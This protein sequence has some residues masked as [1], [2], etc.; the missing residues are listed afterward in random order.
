MA[1]DNNTALNYTDKTTI[2]NWFKTGLKPSQQ[3]FWSTWD[4]YWHKSEKLPI[5]SIS[6]LGNLLDGKAEEN[7]T[8]TNYATKEA[9]DNEIVERARVDALKLNKPTTNATSDYVLLADGSTAPKSDFGKVDKVMG[10]APDANKNVD[11]SGVA[12][13][14]TNA[15]QRFSGLADRSSDAT[16]N[17]IMGLD[18]SGNAAKITQSARLL[19]ATLQGT[20][21]EQA[22]RIGNLLN[23]GNG[24]S[25][26][27]SV[28]LISPPLLQN[29]RNNIE[30]VLLRGANLLLNN[31]D[32]SISI[33]DEGKSVIQRI[34]NEQIINNSTTELLFYYNFYQFTTGTYY[35]KITSGVKIYFTTLD[36][37]IV[38]EIENI[39]INAITWDINY[40]KGVIPKNTDSASGGYVSITTLS[41]VTELPIQSLKSSPLFSKDDDFYIE[42]TLELG[43]KWLHKSR[44]SYFS[45]IG[46]GDSSI[47]NTLFNNS[48]IYLKYSHSWDA[49][50]AMYNN[51]SRISDIVTPS[52][53]TV[54]VIKT[55][56]I[57]RMVIGS[58]N[59]NVII[60]NMDY[61]SLFMAF[62]GNEYELLTQIKIIKAFKI[63]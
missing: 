36:L 56:G 9:L 60:P 29:T 44:Y 34:P 2:K 63:K 4:S 47:P 41:P 33:C 57:C 40:N 5:S 23:G 22:L 32:M 37:Q 49:A 43:P 10:V 25:G 6:G 52:K 55:K 15:N 8:H 46:L 28:N 21:S 17:G 59:V 38:D 58:S 18:N 16:F 13:N 14:W 24:S 62:T 19:E 53:I 27:I 48:F 12:L 51:D 1:L 26:A 54:N 7:H 11:F 50:N 31:T 39:D 20:T 45:F 35:L 3:Q 30:Y 61:F 42:F